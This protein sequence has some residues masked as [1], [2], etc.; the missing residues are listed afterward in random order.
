MKKVIFQLYT[1]FTSKIGPF[2][3]NPEGVQ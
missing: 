3:K 2:G 1:F